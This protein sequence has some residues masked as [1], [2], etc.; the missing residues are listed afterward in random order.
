[1]S[2]IEQILAEINRRVLN[3]YNSE[4]NELDEAAQGAL[5]S[6]YYWITEQAK[7]VVSAEGEIVQS[8]SGRKEILFPK[9]NDILSH[10]DG[11]E[12]VTVIFCHNE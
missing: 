11:G 1:M 3:D 5:S 12:K 10:F 4:D 8:Y 6:M 7:K 2:I 9:Q